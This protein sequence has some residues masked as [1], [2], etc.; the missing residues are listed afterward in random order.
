MFINIL[1]VAERDY[2]SPKTSWYNRYSAKM[3]LFGDS[4]FGSVCKSL[5]IDLQAARLIIIAWLAKGMVGDPI[6]SYLESPDSY[7][8]FVKGEPLKIPT[9]DSLREILSNGSHA[10]RPQ[11]S[12]RC[13]HR[14]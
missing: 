8:R 3:L 14:N 2:L 4:H 7:K 1:R 5:G 6:F 12:G 10:R 9:Y 13:P 11:E